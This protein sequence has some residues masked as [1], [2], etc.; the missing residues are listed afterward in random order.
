MYEHSF[1]FCLSYI[2]WHP[3]HINEF[4]TFIVAFRILNVCLDGLQA[5]LLSIFLCLK[6]KVFHCKRLLHIIIIFDRYA[7]FLML[8]YMGTCR[9]G[10]IPYMGKGTILDWVLMCTVLKNNSQKCF[11]MMGV[12]YFKWICLSEEKHQHLPTLK[13][14]TSL[15][16]KKQWGPVTG[17]RL[18]MYLILTLPFVIVNVLILLTF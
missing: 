10:T 2:T 15:D 11:P 9:K 6:E 4:Y 3:F 14:I 8:V 18:V 5:W 16:H 12:Q 13:T 7:S 1:C 17:H